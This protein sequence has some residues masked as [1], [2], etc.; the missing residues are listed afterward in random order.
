[1]LAPCQSMRATICFESGSTFPRCK[2]GG[3]RIGAVSWVELSMIREHRNHVTSADAPEKKFWVPTL[4]IIVLDVLA[5]QA[6]N[7]ILLLTMEGG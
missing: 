4:N 3:R 7:F 2:S 6:S 1:M 5:L